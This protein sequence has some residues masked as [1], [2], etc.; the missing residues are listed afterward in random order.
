MSAL[1]A[2]YCNDKTV[3]VNGSTRPVG[4]TIYKVAGKRD[5]RAIAARFNAKCWNF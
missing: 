4:G 3:R 5:A 1:Y 2:H